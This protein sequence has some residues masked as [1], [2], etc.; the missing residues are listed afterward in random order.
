M[1]E[2]KLTTETTKRASAIC[3]IK[4]LRILVQTNRQLHKIFRSKFEYNI[5]NEQLCKVWY[6]S[7]LVCCSHVD[8]RVFQT[9]DL[10]P[11][12]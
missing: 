2:N 4:K 7:D 5:N 1:H 8:I 10:S 3:L 9:A 11:V 6:S 12:L